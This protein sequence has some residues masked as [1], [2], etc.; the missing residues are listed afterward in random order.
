MNTDRCKQCSYSAMCLSNVYE[1]HFFRCQHC[2]KLC[3]VFDTK[4]QK[5][6]GLPLTFSMSGT[7]GGL[8]G[9]NP[10]AALVPHGQVHLVSEI[11][12]AHAFKDSFSGHGTCEPCDARAKEQ[13]Q[14]LMEVQQQQQLQQLQKQMQQGSTSIQPYYPASSSM[15][16]VPPAQLVNLNLN[17]SVTYVPA[18]TYYDGNGIQVAPTK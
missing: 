3:V 17:P 10:Y 13:L 16:D 18:I 6:T 7:P 15:T 5:P 4:D 12:P 2:N 8:L 11:C 14:Q 1:R 9:K